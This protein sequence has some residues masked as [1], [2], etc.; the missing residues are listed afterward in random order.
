MDAGQLLT[1]KELS[2]Q[3]GIPIPTIRRAKDKG[4]IPFVQISG[5]GGKLRFPPNAIDRLITV[6]TNPPPEL[7][8][9]LPGRR[10]KWMDVPAQTG[11]R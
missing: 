11:D 5:K 9:K 2:A 7:P 6:K 8:T 3:T 4:Q 1:L 10:P